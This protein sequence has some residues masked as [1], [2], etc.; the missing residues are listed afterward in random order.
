M[1]MPE[2]P[3]T[4]TLYHC[5]ECNTASP[6]GEPHVCTFPDRRTRGETST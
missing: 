5:E 3:T 6:W 4:V 2:I 1:T